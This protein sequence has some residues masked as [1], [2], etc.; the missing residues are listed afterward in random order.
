MLITIWDTETTG[1]L[2]PNAVSVKE[3]P[4]IIEFFGVQINENFEIQ[5][6]VEMLINPQIPL[7][8]IITKITHIT[9]DMLEKKNDFALSYRDI[10]GVFLG[11]DVSV[12]HNISFDDTMLANELL[13]IDKLINFP[14][15]VHHVCTVQKSMS[16]RG[17]RLKLTEL[18]E[19]A[20]GKPLVDAHRAKQDVYGLVRCFHAMVEK[21]LISLKDYE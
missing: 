18:H 7:P 16:I 10:A 21:G 14:W 4:H 6:E 12:A 17:H 11:S 1:L 5:K 8:E 15:P 13:R 3:Q 2:K 20:T 9:D 19:W